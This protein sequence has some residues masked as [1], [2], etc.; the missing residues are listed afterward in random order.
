MIAEMKKTKFNNTIKR[1]YLEN[2]TKDRDRREKNNGKNIE[3]PIQES[4]DKNNKEKEIEM[5][6]SLVKFLS[7]F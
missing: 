6:K 7:T 2:R 3:K 4:Q 5:R 1:Q